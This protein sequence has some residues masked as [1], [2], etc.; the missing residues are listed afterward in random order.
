MLHSSMLGVGTGLVL[1]SVP[2]GLELSVMVATIMP[3]VYLGFAWMYGKDFEALEESLTLTAL[4]GFNLW[5][6]SKVALENQ[7]YFAP[8]S[9]LVH[10]L[11]DTLHVVGLYPS[12]KHVH[13]CSPM[14]PTFCAWFDV[15]MS[16]SLAGCIWFFSK[17]N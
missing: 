8:L 7:P 17:N 5:C 11:V 1:Y 9:I 6:L 12:S 4:S 14:Y 2:Y 10:G 15:A 3:G 16:T 13:S